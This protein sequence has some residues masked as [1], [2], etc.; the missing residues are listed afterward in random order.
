MFQPQA[1]PVHLRAV[2]AME[3]GDPRIAHLK[4]LLHF[5]F[6]ALKLY[7]TIFKSCRKALVFQSSPAVCQG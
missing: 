3:D 7:P 6:K 2:N 4:I 1:H 5:S